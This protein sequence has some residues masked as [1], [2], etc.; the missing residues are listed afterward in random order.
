MRNLK[1]LNKYKQYRR[2]WNQGKDRPEIRL[3]YSAYRYYINREY[4]KLIAYMLGKETFVTERMNEGKE[5]H[6]YLEVFGPPA[7]LI[8]LIEKFPEFSFIVDYKFGQLNGYQKQLE[9]YMFLLAQ[10]EHY[11]YRNRELKIEVQG[12][13]YVVTGVIDYLV[14]N[15]DKPFVGLLAQVKPVYMAGVMQD[16]RLLNTKMYQFNS[17]K[18]NEWTF[19]YFE[20]FNTVLDLLESGDYKYLLDN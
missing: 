17:A 4:D 9:N 3:S 19:I 10:G 14:A 20:L 12:D 6:E 8:E 13:G 5:V 1:I 11:I 16:V 2:L 7:E 15:K 18:I